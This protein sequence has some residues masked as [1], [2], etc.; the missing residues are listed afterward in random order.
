MTTTSYQV[1]EVIVNRKVA[2]MR[3]I[4]AVI[5]ISFKD[6]IA[7]NNRVLFKKP[8][9]FTTHSCKLPWWFF[10]AVAV[11]CNVAFWQ[12][13]LLYL[14]YMGRWDFCDESCHHLWLWKCWYQLRFQ[15]W[16]QCSSHDQA[17]WEI[18]KLCPYWCIYTLEIILVRWSNT[19]F[20]RR[21]V[22]GCLHIQMI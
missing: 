9:L 13:V 12:R 7:T 14:E 1:F 20:D 22:K 4:S 17:R 16:L 8:I 15:Q 11:L 6:E 10:N 19:S 3:G 21:I 2:P 18:L 5:F